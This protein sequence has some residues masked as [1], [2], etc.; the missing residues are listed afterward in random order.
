MVLY[1]VGTWLT[2]SN[3]ESFDVIYKPGQQPVHSGIYR[4][5]GCGREVVAEHSR[6]LPPQNHHQHQVHQGE[7][8]WRM[9][10][11]CDHREK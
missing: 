6:A 1:K 8:R 7:V 11:Y 9:A 2:Q 4:C 5:L 3:D 10:A